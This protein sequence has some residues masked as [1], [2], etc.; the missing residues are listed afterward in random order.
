MRS[1]RGFGAWTGQ[2]DG[3]QKMDCLGLPRTPCMI[4]VRVEDEEPPPA[5][6]GVYVSPFMALMLEAVRHFD[7]SEESLSEE[8]SACGILPRAEG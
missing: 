1:S 4:I 8:G 3:S 6:D 2:S 5:T 7:I